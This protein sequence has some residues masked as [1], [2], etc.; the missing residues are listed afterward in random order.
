M[1]NDA[2]QLKKVCG[3]AN[4]NIFKNSAIKIREKEAAWA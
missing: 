2:H 4:I 1:K 3:T